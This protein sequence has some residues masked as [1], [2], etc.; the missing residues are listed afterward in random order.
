MILTS[1]FWVVWDTTA[2]VFFSNMKALF[3]AS[4][5]CAF[6]TDCLSLPLMLGYSLRMSFTSLVQKS[7]T[8]SINP[9]LIL[10]FHPPES[11]G[12]MRRSLAT[13]VLIP[14]P[15]ATLEVATLLYGNTQSML[16]P[17]QVM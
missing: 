17:E 9:F 3:L 16:S 15:M 10:S 5:S 12:G 2:M 11:G 1:M 4:S 7:S 8:T 6:T 14:F 13:F